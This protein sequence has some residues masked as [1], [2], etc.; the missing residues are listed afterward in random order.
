MEDA[1]APSPAPSSRRIASVSSLGAAGVDDQRQ[2]R[3]ARRTDV[4]PEA[5]AL[6]GHVGHAARRRG[7]SSRARSRRSRPPAASAASAQQVVDV[8]LAH[9]FVVGMHAAAGPE[10]GV[11]QRPARARSRTPPAWCR[12]TARGR[13]ARRPSPRARRRCVRAARESSGGSGNRRTCEVRDAM[14]APAAP[15]AASDGLRR[16]GRRDRG[17]E[18]LFDLELQAACLLVGGKRTPTPCVRPPE[19]L[20]GVIQATLPATG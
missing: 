14:R 16:L 11:A 9:A 10:V 3:C 2:R 5:L 1:T 6:P 17:A 8:G 13:P 15:R 20:A 18:H 19:A 4:D 12:C 7:G